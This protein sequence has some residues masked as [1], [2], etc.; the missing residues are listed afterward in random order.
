MNKIYPDLARLA[1]QLPD[2][3]SLPGVTLEWLYGGQIPCFTILDIS[4]ATVDNWMVLL[5]Q[6]LENWPANRPYVAIH[7]ASVS[8]VMLT[9]YARAK[10]TELEG[11]NPA[12]QGRVAIILPRTFVA[13]LIRVYVRT[14]RRQKVVTGIY[15]AR[16]EALEWIS[17]IVPTQPA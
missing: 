9:P 4:R 1:P 13:Q 7:D 3:T 6:L 17:E 14:L 11:V 16:D 2:A 10:I 5:R 8:G 15:F 12:L